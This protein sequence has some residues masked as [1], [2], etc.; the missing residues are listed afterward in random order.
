MRQLVTVIALAAGFSLAC[1]GIPPVDPPVASMRQYVLGIVF[2]GPAWN[3]GPPSDSLCAAGEEYRRGRMRDG[4]LAAAGTIHDHA[5]LAGI[6]IFRADST[7]QAAAEAERDPLVVAGYQVV[8]LHPWYS[9][10]GIGD[11]V[12][13]ALRARPDTLLVQDS[14]QLGFLKRGERWTANTTDEVQAIQKGHMENITRLAAEGSLVMAGPFTD[15]GALRGIF[16]FRTSGL[17]EARQLA[18]SDPA[19]IAGRLV[20][21]LV[22]L[23]LPE[24]VIPAGEDQ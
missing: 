24:G 16:V 9:A 20:V 4:L 8:D 10:A 18:A 11:R 5:A 7:S 6:M 23:S 1:A 12:A 2:R 15:D 17:E 3:A 19:V 13:G 21:D 22:S 14:Y